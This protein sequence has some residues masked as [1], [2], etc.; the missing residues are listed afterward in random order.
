[1]QG[2]FKCE[3]KYKII[4][5]LRSEPRILQASNN[6]VPERLNL[7]FSFRIGSLAIVNA[8]PEQIDDKI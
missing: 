6:D 5:S 4:V 1:M 3:L 8:E 2:S 7:L